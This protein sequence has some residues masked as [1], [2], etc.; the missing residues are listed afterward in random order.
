MSKELSGPATAA[1]EAFKKV[2]RETKRIDHN[3]FVRAW[4][5]AAT[6]AIE[7]KP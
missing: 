5:A 1:F 6:A 2:W 7:W 3:A 4:D